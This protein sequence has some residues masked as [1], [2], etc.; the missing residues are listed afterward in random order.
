MF[1]HAC[2]TEHNGRLLLK[3]GP[4]TAYGSLTLQTVDY[5]N[6]CK[7][8]LSLAIMQQSAIT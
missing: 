6:G 8:I 1:A 4:F 2:S 3:A 5:W 7:H